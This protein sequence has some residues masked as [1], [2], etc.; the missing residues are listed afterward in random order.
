M[1]K[2]TIAAAVLAF[3]IF[4]AVAIAA[5]LHTFGTGQ[6]TTENTK[7]Y[8]LGATI[9]NDVGEYGGIYQGG[10]HAKVGTVKYSFLSDGQVAGGAPRWSIPLDTDNNTKTVDSYAFLDVNGCGGS[11]GHATYV[12]TTNPDCQVFINT[13]GSYPN[14]AALVA[15]NPTWRVD[16]QGFIIADVDGSYHVFDARFGK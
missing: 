15:A 5:S 14:W 3:G 8:G 12:S 13:G 9:V 11:A 10:S 4:T 16:G 2:I 1:R 7:V 6:V